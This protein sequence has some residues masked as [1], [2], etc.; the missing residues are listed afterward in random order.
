VVELSPADV[1]TV[2]CL[3]RRAGRAVAGSRER[4]AALERRSE[5]IVRVRVGGRS[6]SARG[7]PTGEGELQSLLRSALA[8]AR[9][10]A[11]SPDWQL[12][13]ARDPALAGDLSDPRLATLDEDAAGELLA[14]LG[15]GRDTVRL[16]WSRSRLAVAASFHPPRVL[17]V[18]GYELEARIG[19]RPGAGFA[20]VAG[21]PLDLAAMTATLDR[22]RSL[23]ASGAPTAAPAAP[24]AIVLAPEAAAIFVRRLAAVALASDARAE[25]ARPQPGVPPSALTLVDTPLEP[26]APRLPFDLDGCPKSDRLMLSGGTVLG[27]AHDLDSAARAGV[28]PTGHGLAAGVARPLHLSISPGARAEPELLAAAAGGL[29]V[30]AVERLEIG[31]SDGLPFRALLRGVRAIDPSGRIGA[32]IEPQI[33]TSSL[34]ALLAGVVEVGAERRAWPLDPSGLGAVRAAALRLTFSGELRP[35]A[36]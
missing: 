30:G 8:A 12:D 36:G 16:H 5:L 26:G 18:S 25:R 21:D 28:E 19:P 33:W 29:R 31:E 9:C 34:V 13:A 2:A 32:A 10:A 7:E 24:A 20:A 23:A 3:D 35:A 22:A 14:K 15:A 4:R 1:T 11:P 17:A 6:G 27:V